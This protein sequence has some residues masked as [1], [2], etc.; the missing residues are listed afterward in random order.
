MSSTT[1][2]REVQIGVYY[3]DSTTRTYALSVADSVNVNAIR[4]RIQEIN[5]DKTGDGNQYLAP[6]K[7]TFVSKTGSPMAKISFANLVETTKEV[8]YNG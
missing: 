4:E 6:M 7:A 2:E 5:G 8:I 3:E 1:T